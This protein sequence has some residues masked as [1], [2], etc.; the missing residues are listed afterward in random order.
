MLNLT[1]PDLTVI[2]DR[3]LQCSLNRKFF[4]L[5][6]FACDGSRE[7]TKGVEV[8]HHEMEER[9]KVRIEGGESLWTV[10]NGSSSVSRY[11]TIRFPIRSLVS[12]RR[13]PHSFQL[14]IRTEKNDRPQIK[15]CH[16]YPFF[17]PFFSFTHICIRIHNDN[18]STLNLTSSHAANVENLML[19]MWSFTILLE[20]FVCRVT[21]DC[22]LYFA[23]LT[24][25][26]NVD[27]TTWCK[28]VDD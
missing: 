1:E 5:F 13:P 23:T 24:T 12:I 7:K 9:W 19:T 17:P 4:F 11:F 26:R 3:I 27:K 20:P 10:M 16:Q 15:R 14:G 6:P 21:A 8:E 18:D 25:W 28:W 22:A 2:F